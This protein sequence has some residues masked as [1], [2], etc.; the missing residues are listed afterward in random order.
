MELSTA[1]PLVLE[2][3]T[4]ACSQKAD[5]LKPSERQLQQWETQPGFYSI[6]SVCSIELHLVSAEYFMFLSSLINLFFRDLKF[7]TR[8]FALI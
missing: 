8:N 4:N 5:I 2:T 7:L 1:G 3:L 6:L